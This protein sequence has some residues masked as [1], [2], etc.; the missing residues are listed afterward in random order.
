MEDRTVEYGK[1]IDGNKIWSALVML[2]TMCLLLWGQQGAEAA[3]FAQRAGSMSEITGI[4][5]STDADKTRIVVDGTKETEYK[6]A[7][8]RAKCLI[9]KSIAIGNKP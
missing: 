6:S 5:V 8:Y 3:G 2:L 1:E 7:V 4:R 9:L